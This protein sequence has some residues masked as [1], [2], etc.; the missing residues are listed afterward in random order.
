[1]I[2]RL[3]RYIFKEL[4]ISIIASFCFFVILLILAT[5]FRDLSEML[6]GGKLGFQL[7]CQLML[8]LLPVV[9]VYA[10]PLAV[11]SGILIAFGRLSSNSEI[12]AMKSLGLSLYQIAS[13]VFLIAFICMVLSAL[14]SLH[15]APNALL[16]YRTLIAKSIFENPIGFMQE[17][18]FIKEFPG[19]VIYLNERDGS[20]LKDFWIWEM[21]E[22]NRVE[23]FI[24]SKTGELSYDQNT[25]ALTLNL[26][27]GSI[28][29]RSGA[30]NKTIQ[31]DSPKI[32]FFENLPISLP[33]NDIFGR[34]EN[35]ILRF[36][37][38]AF[39]QLMKERERIIEKDRAREVR[40]SD[41]RANIQNYIHKNF[42]QAYSVFALAI[43]G[44][45][46][47]IKV[48]RKE[49]YVNL[50]LALAVAFG[51]HFLFILVS[52]FDEIPGL[53]SDLILWV[54]NILFQSLGF[55]LFAKSANQ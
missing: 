4:F 13:S 15:F 41:E 27:N 5:T 45:P 43:I 49:S 38:M 44:I 31:V 35:Q 33:L 14:T 46:L 48:G 42:S 1:M 8:L 28:E 39:A 30:F 17:K 54:P 19:Y 47:A 21:D 22:S 26:N 3:H 37:H 9:S 10:I 2:N 12:T 18:K 50:F 53:R 32:L 24:R 51:Y 55:W 52:W 34:S 16:S 23:L 40:F 36:K 29:R 25:N 11:L 7:F 20:K 6:N